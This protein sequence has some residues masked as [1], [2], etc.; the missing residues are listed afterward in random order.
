MCC[1]NILVVRKVDTV[2][3]IISLVAGIGSVG[4]SGDNGLALSA[5]LNAPAGLYLDLSGNLYIADSG[6]GAIRIVNTKGI[7]K[8]VVGTLGVQGFLDAVPAT[9]AY[10]NS[11][12]DVCMDTSGNLIIA[13]T[14]NNLIRRVMVN[15]KSPT[16][17]GRIVTI[18]G[19]NGTVPDNV[20]YAGDG[21]PA[22]SALLH[23]PSGVV[24]DAFGNLYI[25]DTVN[26]AVR[27]V[28]NQSKLHR[29]GR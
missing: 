4:A 13:D 19:N 18:V 6:N 28:A 1:N 3:G 25:T 12:S 16:G 22:T 2:G 15:T 5:M 20:G 10:L 23:S 14:L 26:N 24:V 9:S 8:T 11:P 27:L 17:F 29:V 21:Q 7:I